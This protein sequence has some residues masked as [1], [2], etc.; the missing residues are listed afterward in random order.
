MRRG[1]G[2]VGGDRTAKQDMNMENDSYMPSSDI[3]NLQAFY[4]FLSVFYL[5]F[6]YDWRS[7]GSSLNLPRHSPN[8]C[9]ASESPGKLIKT[10]L[11]PSPECLI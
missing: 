6:M 7:L 1:Q 11:D 8:H 3:I 9:S 10:D 5:P 2:S 4:L